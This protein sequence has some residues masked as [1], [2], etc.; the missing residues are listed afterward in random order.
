MGDSGKDMP[1]V[2]LEIELDGETPDN[3]IE[4]KGLL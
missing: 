1:T 3:F 2:L 4:F